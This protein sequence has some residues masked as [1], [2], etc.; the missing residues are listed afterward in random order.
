M[1]LRARIPSPITT[2]SNPSHTLFCCTVDDRLPL[3]EVVKLGLG[4]ARGIQELHAQRILFE[5]LKPA[6]WVVLQEARALFG[7][8]LWPA[9]C[10][11]L[12]SVCG[13]LSRSLNVLVVLAC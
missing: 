3:P 1:N 2:R 5:D 8:L 6:K 4:I 12:A 9:D 10:A 7:L 11:P 13:V